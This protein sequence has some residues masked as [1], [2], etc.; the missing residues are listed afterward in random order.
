MLFFVVLALSSFSFVSYFFTK[1]R[2]GTVLL[3]LPPLALPPVL[4]GSVF[5]ADPALLS[6]CP[7]SGLLQL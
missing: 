3:P 2:S 1:V 6:D 7:T 4:V 5:G